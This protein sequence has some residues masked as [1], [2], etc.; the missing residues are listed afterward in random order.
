MPTKSSRPRAL[1]TGAS[2]GIGWVYAEHLARQ[3]YDLILTA[4]RRDRLEELAAR[5]KQDGADADIIVADLT[6]PQGLAKVEARASADEAIALLINNAGFA[7]YRPFAEIDTRTIDELIGIHIR[8]VTHLTRAMLP[9]MIGRGSGAI[10]NIA[11]LLSLTGT[12]APNPLPYRATY[13]G[14]KAFM[15]AFTQALSGEIAGTGVHV[16]V[17]LPGRVA[18]EFHTA[19]GI[20]TSKMPPAM[21][22]EDVVTASLAALA[23]K[24]VVCIP[25]LGDAALFAQLSEAQIKV[26]RASAMQAVM[27]ER[28]RAAATA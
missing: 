21:S 1:V 16:Q 28:Y 19:H 13:A 7:G 18:T 2:S 24:E 3:G 11:S 20:D 5:L 9:G 17:C 26:F 12:I 25:G 4:R 10:V 14:A 22:A 15:L 23:Q 6:D 8:A 27:A